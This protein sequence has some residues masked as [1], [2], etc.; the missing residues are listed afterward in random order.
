MLLHSCC[1]PC[2]GAMIEEMARLGLHITVFFY[3][4][5][6][7]PRAEYELRKEE[8]K[9]YAAELG[10]PF[11]DADYDATAWFQRAKGMEH[12]PER[13]RR[14]TMCFDMRL[15]R[16]A[17]HAHENGFDCIA[18]T[19]A[20]SRWKDQAQVND[21]GAR[22]AARYPG[23][24]YWFHDWQGERLTRRKYEI[25]AERRFYK[26]E[27][28]GCAYSLRDSNRWR[29]QQGMGPV[30]LGTS[31]FSDPQ[32]DAEEESPEVV[33]AFFEQ[34]NN[35]FDDPSRLEIYSQREKNTQCIDNN[36]W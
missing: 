10:V 26:Q 29:R 24:E 36:N 15:E 9:R 1:A 17:L 2:S 18:T 21:S 12:D 14:C 22:A 28:C 4:P 11:V 6:I 25:S 27:Y 35:Q 30:K 20:T 5:N 23:L 16:T 32:A 31:W 34:A 13:G 3:N 19:N 8:N 33:A 7:H